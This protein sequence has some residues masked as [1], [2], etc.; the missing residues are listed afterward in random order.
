[1]KTTQEERNG[2]A[3]YIAENAGVIQA[4]VASD[5]LSDFDALEK[6]NAALRERAEKAEMQAAKL[7]EQI[8]TWEVECPNDMHMWQC[9]VFTDNAECP[10]N[11]AECWL[12]WA[13]QP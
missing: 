4:H 5:I 7:A 10:K 12:E 2:L 3:R 8:D 13:A 6:E 11:Q 9:K 1:M